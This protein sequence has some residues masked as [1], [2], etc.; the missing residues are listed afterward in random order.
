MILHE[1]NL[2][3]IFDNNFSNILMCKRVTPPFKNMYNLIGGKVEKD[4][5]N[6]V[7]AYREMMEETTLTILD[8]KLYHIMDL[9][10]YYSGQ[11]IYVYAGVLNKNYISL[12]DKEHPLHCISIQSDFNN[13]MLAGNGNLFHIIK[14]SLLVVKEKGGSVNE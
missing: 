5:N 13:N 1:T 6:T 11:R 4:E 2:I 3:A 7:S 8:V 12:L 9:V 14:Q 10:Y